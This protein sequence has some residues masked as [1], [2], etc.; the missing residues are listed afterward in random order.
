M[1]RVR[2]SAGANNAAMPQPPEPTGVELA[3]FRRRIDFGIIIWS[4]AGLLRT[5]LEF[6]DLQDVTAFV[7]GSNPDIK[8]QLCMAMGEVLPLVPFIRRM[9]MARC[10]N[11]RKKLLTEVDYLATFLGDRIT[12]TLARSVRDWKTATFELF[13]IIP[14]LFPWS[15]DREQKRASDNSR[16]YDCGELMHVEESH[17]WEEGDVYRRCFDPVYSPMARCL[18]LLAKLRMFEESSEL[19]IP[20]GPHIRLRCMYGDGNDINISWRSEGFWVRNFGSNC[21]YCG[22]ITIQ[23]IY[24]PLFINLSAV[25]TKGRSPPEGE[26]RGS[27]SEKV[28]TYV[29]ST[30]DVCSENFDR[31]LVSWEEYGS[32]IQ[33]YDTEAVTKAVNRHAVEKFGASNVGEFG[34]V[35]EFYTIGFEVLPFEVTPDIEFILAPGR[36]GWLYSTIMLEHA[37]ELS[38]IGGLW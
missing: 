24:G 33:S 37:R 3:V 34:V 6:L 35:S 21:T 27:R 28:S 14:A 13:Q 16:C 20:S 4:I 26:I 9:H 17:E 25:A 1:S 32:L 15:V 5:V 2:D 7:C 8:Q 36:L 18:G 38:R 19:S 29:F 22:D 23:R 12:I 10:G 11:Y 30:S 31:S